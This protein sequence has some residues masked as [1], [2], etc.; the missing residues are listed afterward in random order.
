MHTSKVGNVGGVLGSAAIA[1]NLVRRWAPGLTN[2]HE[3]VDSS[4]TS[5]FVRFIQG[6]IDMF[7]A[8]SALQNSLERNQGPK[9]KTSKT[10]SFAVTHGHSL[11]VSIFSLAILKHVR[12]H[13]S[14]KN[15][16]ET[17]VLTK[18]MR[19]VDRHGNSSKVDSS[20]K[21]WCFPMSNRPLKLVRLKFLE[22]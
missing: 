1:V 13:S 7:L 20:C 5:R 16:G 9:A 10:V 22:E 19:R 15:Y 21:L 17:L 18:S 4:C 12:A 11:M 8:V 2:K 6:F 3:D 14:Q